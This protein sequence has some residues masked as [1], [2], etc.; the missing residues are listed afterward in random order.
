MPVQVTRWKVGDQLFPTEALALAYEQAEQDR[1]RSEVFFGLL[2]VEMRN[3]VPQEGRQQLLQW[4]RRA[5]KAYLAWD[6]G[7]DWQ[8]FFTAPGADD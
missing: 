5:V 6:R 3:A 4:Q 7:G 1:A 2:A 8:N